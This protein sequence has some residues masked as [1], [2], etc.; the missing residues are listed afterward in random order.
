VSS[1]YREISPSA[2]LAPFI[3]CFWA[4][5]V[6]N[7]IT[8][9]I[10]PDGCADILFVSHNRHIET[11]IVGVMTRPHLVPLAA[12]T[13]ILGIRFHPGMAGVCIGIPIEQLN[14]RTLP[15]HS[16]VGP[17]SRDI[18]KA[19]TAR[20]S[21]ERRI[22]AIEDHL[23]NLPAISSIQSAIGELTGRKGQLSMH[24]F[25]AAAGVSERQLRR[26]C[27]KNSGLS[28]KLLAR[29]LRFRNATA[30]L[31]SAFTSTA[32]I[33]CDCGYFDEAHMIRDFKEFAG[34]TPRQYSFHRA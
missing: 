1:P 17:V 22:T 34:L 32:T 6:S 7:D 4:G 14:D 13:S 10:L 3:E 21:V 8:A 16:A 2:P 25:A 31:R 24:D 23:I 5:E 26:T 11:Q 29:I 15:I 27:L 19:G 12:G 33:A 18:V 9:R 28:P 30:R 20:T